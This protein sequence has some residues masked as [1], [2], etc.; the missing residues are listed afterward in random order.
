MP[1]L[2]NVLYLFLLVGSFPW[3][4][5]SAWRK[6]KYRQ[7]WAAKFLGQVPR[8]QHSGPRIW[9]H[10]VSVGEVNLLEPLL[11]QLAEDQPDAV[12]VISTT[13][14]TGFELANKKYADYVVTYCPLDFSWAVRR[15]MRRIQPD[16]LVLAELE[17]WP[18]L[19]RAAKERQASV[20]VINGR[21]SPHSFRGYQKIR[22]IIA[23]TL[24]HIDLIAAQN[25]EYAER[26][27]ALG[28]NQEAVIITGSI[29]FDGAR[30][31]RANP[32]TS[33]L[34]R[35]WAVQEDDRVFLAGST[36]APEEEFAVDA[37]LSLTKTHPHWRLIIVPRH[38]D[39]FD[40]VAA[41][42]KRKQVPWQRRSQ[43][44][45]GGANP[46][47]KI[48]LVDVI[49]ELGAWWGMADV[50]FV[51]GSLS[52]RGG[53]NMIEPAAYGVAV[54]FGPNTW[55]FRDVVSLLLAGQAA[56]VV[57]NREELTTFVRRCATQ[58]AFRQR[59]GDSAC[60]LVLEQQGA[61]RRTS[62]R[63]VD[64]LRS[65]PSGTTVRPGRHAA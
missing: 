56:E 40:E 6:G 44:E 24:R 38:P 26:F 22:P 62:Q 59:L 1:Y 8:C 65:G 19:I 17:L 32:A 29:K 35:L 63:L 57:R 12:C 11:R 34:R 31:D 47:A 4:L 55:N 23:S 25:R 45:A 27:L 13:T 37:W 48:L 10:A 30:T 58:P 14:R 46:P 15:A 41:M 36:Q 3:L 42:L 60:Q 52:Q 21:L 20:A 33:A 16:L 53:Q 50:G 5:Y 43:L 61:T 18:N 49:G 7:G 39:R 9:L 51:G 54:S 64:L 2:Y 28:A